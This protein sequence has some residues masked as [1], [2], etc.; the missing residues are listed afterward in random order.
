MVTR[1]A[2]SGPRIAI[3]SASSGPRIAIRIATRIE[4]RTRSAAPV[5][6]LHRAVV[7]Q[8]SGPPPPPSLAIHR[9]IA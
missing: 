4:I 7:R 6:E 2:S 9:V 8:T 3:R 1:S 5:Q